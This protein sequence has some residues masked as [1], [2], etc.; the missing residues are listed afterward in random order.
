MSGNATS[1][2]HEF[3]G[4]SFTV[5]DS[6]IPQAMQQVRPLYDQIAGRFYTIAHKST[7]GAL[8]ANN[9]GRLAFGVW[10]SYHV[11]L[12]TLHLGG[13][14]GTRAPGR[15]AQANGLSHRVIAKA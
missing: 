4:Q 15:V 14:S 12:R 7:P 9:H 5:A 11:G 8:P 1:P 2:V 10:P 6:E 3:R 13:P